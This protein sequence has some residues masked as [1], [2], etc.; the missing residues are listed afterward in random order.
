MKDRREKTIV[1]LFLFCKIRQ[2]TSFAFKSQINKMNT[3]IGCSNYQLR[4]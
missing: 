4:K 3:L 2:K 1:I